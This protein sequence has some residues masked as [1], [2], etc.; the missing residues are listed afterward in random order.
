MATERYNFIVSTIAPAMNEEG[1]IDDFCRQYA[2]MLEK[3]PFEGE[4][5]LVDDGS[6]DGTLAKIKENAA[7]YD[8]IRYASHQRNMGLTDALQTGFAIARGEVY[9][10]YPTDLQYKPEDIPKLIAPIAAGADV[11]TG[12]KQGKYNKRFVSTV[13]NAFSRKLFNLKVHDLNSVKAFRREVVDQ[14]FLRKDWHRYLVV[15]AANAGFKVEECKIDLYER[16][17]GES[18]YSIWRIPV[19]VLD[20]LAVKFQITFL[21]KPLLFFGALGSILFILGTIVGFWALYLRYIEH[22]GDRALLYLVILLLGLGGGL[23]MMGFI[24]E[25]QTAIKE[26]I[27]DLRKKTQRMLDRDKNPPAS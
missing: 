3:A 21:K 5:V 1:N 24:A 19:G 27:A 8:F 16:E 6:T 20:M 14:I 9:V 12:W 11:C 10:F 25:G 17:W 15:L 13:Y 23:F 4:L 26:E 18:K 2:A 7:K 22:H